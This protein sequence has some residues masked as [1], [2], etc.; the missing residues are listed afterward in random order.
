MQ[1]G[2]CHAE[3]ASSAFIIDDTQEDQIPQLTSGLMECL[4]HQR[5]WVLSK[6]EG[7]VYM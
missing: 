5:E 1:L 2:N 7:A 4:S 6:C 3:N